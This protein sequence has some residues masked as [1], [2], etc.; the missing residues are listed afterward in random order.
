M[1]DWFCCKKKSASRFTKKGSVLED[2]H[3]IA[4][5]AIQPRPSPSRN[6]ALLGIRRRV[7]PRLYVIRRM[8]VCPHKKKTCT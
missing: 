3:E 6:L 4:M 8:C 5:A 7:L 2:T 1:F